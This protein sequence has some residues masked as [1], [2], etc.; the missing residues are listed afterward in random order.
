MGVSVCVC[1]CVFERNSNVEATVGISQCTMCNEH[2]LSV[3]NLVVLSCVMVPVAVMFSFRAMVPL[4]TEQDINSESDLLAFS[5][6]VKR[7]KCCN[8]QNV[9]SFILHT[10][11]HRVSSEQRHK[12][13]RDVIDDMCQVLDERSARARMISRKCSEYMK[14]FPQLAPV[15]TMKQFR[16]MLAEGCFIQSDEPLFLYT[17]AL[18]TGMHISIFYKFTVWTTR[19]ISGEIGCSLRFAKMLNGQWAELTDAEPGAL[20]VQPQG[21]ADVGITENM[22]DTEGHSSESVGVTQPC[23]TVVKTESVEAGTSLVDDLFAAYQ[24]AFPM[25]DDDDELEMKEVVCDHRLLARPVVVVKHVC[26]PTTKHDLEQA[27]A[28]ASDAN[29]ALVP[30]TGAV[31]S[32][33]VGMTQKDD[34]MCATVDKRDVNTAVVQTETKHRRD[35]KLR[36]VVTRSRSHSN[37][38]KTADYSSVSVSNIVSNSW[39][40]SK[41]A[42]ATCS[43]VRSQSSPSAKRSMT[44]GKYKRRSLHRVQ[45]MYCEFSCHEV[46]VYKEHLRC[47]HD[48]YVCKFA[49]C[50]S[51]WVLKGA[52]KAHEELHS[53]A[54]FRCDKCGWFTSGKA[55]YDR[56]VLKHTDETP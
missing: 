12:S 45:C 41:H 20:S 49:L 44:E 33:D 5:V 2:V 51:N 21:S 42:V 9:P 24:A 19:A 16:A 1:V 17:L 25:S 28:D 14:Q 30:M 56:H 29:A 15:Q 37:K 36:R 3:W 43:R 23:S 48:V 52:C 40:A 32:Q 38:H 31:S 22:L 7:D 34:L 26:V 47:N 54:K 50:T 11:A 10:A 55:E 53:A 39:R 46:N 35:C 18:A 6:T 8:K 27:A 4:P 13:E